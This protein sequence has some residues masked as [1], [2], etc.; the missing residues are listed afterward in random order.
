MLKFAVAAI[1]VGVEHE[2][3]L[4]YS[5]AVGGSQFGLIV[6]AERRQTPREWSDVANHPHAI[7]FAFEDR[8]AHSS[9]P[10]AMLI[11][12]LGHVSQVDLERAVSVGR[13]GF[14][15]RELFH[16]IGQASGGKYGVGR[17][18]SDVEMPRQEF[19]VAHVES[20]AKNERPRWC[21]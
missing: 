8:I 9:D 2:V 4:K 21:G 7:E 14:A 10:H 18:S 12:S 15:R 6:I 19:V 20:Q 5:F 13:N 3:E 16:R 17:R 11:E 1:G